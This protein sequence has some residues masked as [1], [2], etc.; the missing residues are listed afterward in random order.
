M[1]QLSVQYVAMR[2]KQGKS[3]NTVRHD[4]NTSER[5]ARWW[6]KSRRVPSALTIEAVEDFLYGPEALADQMQPSSFNVK[7]QELRRFLTWAARRQHVPTNVLDGLQPLPTSQKEYVRLSLVKIVDMIESCS[8]EWERWCLVLASQTLARDGELRRIR[9]KDFDFDTGL[10]AYY[11][12]KTDDPDHLQI[13]PVLDQ[14]YRRWVTWLQ[15][16]QSGFDKAWY[17]IPRRIRRPIPGG[18]SWTYHPTVD[19]VGGLAVVVQ[20]HAAKM[21]GCDQ[22]DLSGQGV[23]LMRRSMA[24]ALYDQLVEQRV[25]DPI[26]VVMCALGHKS[27]DTTERYLGLKADRERRNDL[28]AS[29]KLLWTPQENVYRLGAESPSARQA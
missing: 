1:M 26:R 10:L 25:D 16:K 9:F 6:D 18:H 4:R 24:R 5:F 11:R 29:G 14:G 20:K 7:L 17:A 8:D 23:H 28:L 19:R 27:P 15:D 3:R 13:T 22:G 21:L 12:P 2:V